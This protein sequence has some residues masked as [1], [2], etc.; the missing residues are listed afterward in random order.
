MKSRASRSPPTDGCSRMATSWAT[1]TRSTTGAG[2]WSNS[3]RSA[4]RSRWTTSRASR[5]SATASSWS[6][7]K[8]TTLCGPGRRQRRAGRVHRPRHEGW[9]RVRDRGRGVRCGRPVAAARVQE[10]THQEPAGFPGHFSLEARAWQRSPLVQADRAAP[11]SDRLEPMGWAAPFG[12]YHR[13]VQR[14]LSD[15]R[16]QGESADRDHP[17]GRRGVRPSTSRH[18]C[19]TRRHC[20]HARRHP[21]RERRGRSPRGPPPP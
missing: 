4:G 15:R 13:P 21:D 7:S 12:H 10:R 2:S 3:S 8:G 16:F 6:T 11:P 5:S 20:A 14:L 9:T 17:G 18:A 1:C 19:P